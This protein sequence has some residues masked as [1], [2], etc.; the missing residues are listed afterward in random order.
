MLDVCPGAG[1]MRS[2]VVRN[3]IRKNTVPTTANSVITDSN[4]LALSPLP[5]MSTSGSSSTWMMNCATIT[6][7]NRYDDRLL[8]W[9]MLPVS[10]PLSAEYGRLLAA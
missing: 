6:A 5:R 10:T 7:T 9:A 1:T 4:P 3:V 2:R 8:R